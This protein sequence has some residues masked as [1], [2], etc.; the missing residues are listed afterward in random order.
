MCLIA[1]GRVRPLADPVILALDEQEVRRSDFERYV[2]DLEARQ[3]GPLDP[4]VR[5]ALLDTFLERRVLVLE[6]RARGLLAENAGPEDEQAAVESLLARAA[7]GRI[8]VGDD[9]IERYYAEHVD[10][11]AQ[12]ET[13]TLRQIVVPT[14]NEARDVKRRLQRDPRSFETLAQTTS[15]GPEAANGGLM[16]VFARGELPPELEQAAAELDPG[17]TSAIVETALGKHVLR[18]ELREAARQME[19]A[20]CRP[21]IRALLSAQKAEREH[22]ALVSGLMARAKVNHEAARVRAAEKS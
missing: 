7:G 19:L 20:E 12:P 4:G 17:E 21:R 1:C 3:G 16:G 15:R 9:E 6:A 22:R 14:L 18:L 8:Q 5:D 11:F 2:A 13:I 10:E